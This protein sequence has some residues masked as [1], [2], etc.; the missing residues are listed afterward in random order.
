MHL[1][2]CPLGLLGLLA[3]VK[4]LTND[5]TSYTQPPPHLTKVVSFSISKCFPSQD[6]LFHPVAIHNF[7]KGL[8]KLPIT[9]SWGDPVCHKGRNSSF[10]QVPIMTQEAVGTEA[11]PLKPPG[12]R[13]PWTSI[14]LTTWCN[15]PHLNL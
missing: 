11:I 2:S 10:L 13:F 7:F 9:Q 12:W 8:S 3:L 14:I 1:F 15:Y 5:R 4:R 6:S